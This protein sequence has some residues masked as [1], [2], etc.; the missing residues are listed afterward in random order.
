MNTLRAKT[1]LR[2]MAIVAS[3][4]LVSCAA[5]GAVDETTNNT[6]VHDTTQSHED[7]HADDAS[8]PGEDTAQTE[9]TA[10]TPRDTSDISDPD[11]ATNADTNAPDATPSDTAA[12]DAQ[13]DST[14]EDT[15]SGVAD[16]KTCETA[17]DITDGGLWDS[18][19]TVGAN[20]NY[21]APFNAQGCPG[22]PVTGADQVFVLAPDTTT[23]YDLTITSQDE[24]FRPVAYIRTDCT[25]ID[26]VAGSMLDAT[27]LYLHD[28]EVPG[29]ER[30]YL[31]VD[32]HASAREG[33]YSLNV[34]TH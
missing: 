4:A 13:S 16:G 29:G 7:T 11:D 23:T 22:A 6:P 12:D 9:D 14:D 20:N 24:A 33:A 10:D 27:V 21:N 34:E 19:T 18:Q 30:Y 17:I 25:Q 1:F 15:Q 3:A 2:L 26:C 28:I 8:A 31:I 5:D 32:T